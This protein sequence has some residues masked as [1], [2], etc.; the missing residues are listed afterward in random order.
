[1]PN[2]H[3]LRTLSMIAE[4]IGENEAGSFSLKNN[5]AKKVNNNQFKRKSKR[6]DPTL[7][8]IRVDEVDED[9]QD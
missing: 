1:M 2:D 5:M 8:P 3:P 7:I 9:G 6:L 4:D